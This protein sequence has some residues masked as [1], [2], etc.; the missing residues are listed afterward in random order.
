LVLLL[1]VFSGVIAA[2]AVGM[3]LAAFVFMKKIADISEQQTTISPLADEPW[4]DEL[5]LAATNRDQL[6]IKHLEGPLFFGFARG[7]AEIAALAQSGKLLVLRMDR[8]RFMDQSGAYALHDALVDLKAA[9]LRILI[10]G[11]PVAERDILEALRIV[12]DIV[13]K[14]D[15]F[16][17]FASLR[18]ALPDIA[19]ISGRADTLASQKRA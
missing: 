9:G 2:V 17:D 7:F 14:N 5:E 18:T 15:L 13:P 19:S 16:D 12:P 3:I 11:L 8:V 1:T 10:V 4:A 6:L